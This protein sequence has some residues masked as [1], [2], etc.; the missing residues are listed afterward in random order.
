LLLINLGVLYFGNRSEHNSPK[1][2]KKSFETSYN[3]PLRYF[4]AI[5]SINWNFQRREDIR[6][7]WI[8]YF[9]DKKSAGLTPY[10]KERFEYKFF[11]GQPSSQKC[12]ERWTCVPIT[13]REGE[14][15]VTSLKSEISK[16][17]M[18]VLKHPAEFS[19]FSKKMLAIFEWV[20]KEEQLTGKQFTHFIGVEDD[21]YVRWDLLERE[22]MRES[23]NRLYMGQFHKN[24]PADPSLYPFTFFPDFAT[25]MC[26]I[27]SMDLV[28]WI[29]H[30]KDELNM[31]QHDDCGLAIWLLPVMKTNV[32]KAEQ[33]QW[34]GDT[35][36]CTEREMVIRRLPNMKEKY[37]EHQRHI[38][39]FCNDTKISFTVV[40]P[41]IPIQYLK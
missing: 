39:R 30:N 8:R 2:Q 17:D 19:G 12:D 21:T 38:E 1:P 6:N 14:S 25:G 29:V 31:W 23:K 24:V 15:L 16:G 34:A 33:F 40:Q 35:S 10:Q 4:V 32:N 7:S 20:V 9:T 22:I 28:R 26:Q 37:E 5:K 18:I 27:L 41:V 11:V 3:T 36:K 13:Q